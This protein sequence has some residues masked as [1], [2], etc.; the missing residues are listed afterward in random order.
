MTSVFC[1]CPHNLLCVEYLIQDIK[2]IIFVTIFFLC[3]QVF[4]SWAERLCWPSHTERVGNQTQAILGVPGLRYFLEMRLLS[5]YKRHNKLA[6]CKK[7]RGFFFIFYFCCFSSFF[8]FSMYLPEFFNF[9]SLS[10]KNF[11]PYLHI[12]IHVHT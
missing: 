4:S 8:K 9:F 1:F 6:F 2:Y 12:H 5:S 11:H 10:V 3:G 7:V